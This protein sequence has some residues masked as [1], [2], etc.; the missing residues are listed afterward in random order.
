MR[1]RYRH[2]IRS[3]I[4][5][6]IDE[7]KARRL[8]RV[9]M[10]KKL[11]CNI[12]L[13]WKSLQC[14]ACQS[15]R[16]AASK[17]LYLPKLSV[18]YPPRNHWVTESQAIWDMWKYDLSHGTLHDKRT[19]YHEMHLL[20]HAQLAA[21]ILP[22]EDVFIYNSETRALVC[23]IIRNFCPLTGPL[24]WVDYIAQEA[25][26]YRKPTRVCGLPIM[27]V[28]NADEHMFAAGR[29]R[30]DGPSRVLSWFPQRPCL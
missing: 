14:A 28:C 12:G 16:F 4:Q 5:Q 19:G 23:A 24:K 10:H 30:N 20:V 8:E 7:R 11:V 6:A 21:D 25:L 9:K 29:P 3:N 22:D 26:H 15:A 17:H 18:A 27:R 13:N 2:L 1:P